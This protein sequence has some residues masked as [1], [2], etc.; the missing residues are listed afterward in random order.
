MSRHFVMGVVLGHEH[1]TRIAVVG[2]AILWFMFL[3]M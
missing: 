2:L 3:L 1:E